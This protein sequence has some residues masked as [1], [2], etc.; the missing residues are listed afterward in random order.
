LSVIRW[1]GESSDYE[2]PYHTVCA[3]SL[4]AGEKE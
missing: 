3:F 1:T 2:S 4:S